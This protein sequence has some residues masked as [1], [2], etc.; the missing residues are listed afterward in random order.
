MEPLHGERVEDDE[1]LAERTVRAAIRAYRLHPFDTVD[2]A[3]VAEVAGIPL[4][5]VERL[6]PTWHALLLVTYDRWAQL[7]GTRRKNPPTCTIEHVRL[8]LAEDVADPG[9]VRVLAGLITVASSESGFAELFRKRFE[10]YAEQLTVGL[11]R[12]FDKGSEE[13][14]IPAYQA[15]T[16]L[17]AVYEGLQIQM[18][19][20]PHIDVLVEFDRAANTLRQGWKRHAVPSWDLDEA[21]VRV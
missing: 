7:R 13:A 18:L 19:V 20:R 16:Q 5:T 4:E 1:S 15:A 21:P 9:L 10:E 2:A 11:Q 6:F 17:L 12:D 3:V 14:G 8:T